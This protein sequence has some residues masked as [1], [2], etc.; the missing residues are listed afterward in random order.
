ML[1]PSRQPGSL[2]GV[3]RYRPILDRQCR[4]IGHRLLVLESGADADVAFVRDQLGLQAADLIDTERLLGNAAAEAGAPPVP[5]SGRYWLSASAAL[6]D[7]L[8]AVPP[9]A[10]SIVWLVP[11]Q[12]AAS[13]A[14]Y[15]MCE[16][17]MQRGHHLAVRGPAAELASIRGIE[18]FTALHVPAGD[19][20]ALATLYGVKRSG[21][22]LL[23]EP[24]DDSPDDDPASGGTVRAP[25]SLFDGVEGFAPIRPA[26]A[27]QAGAAP[28]YG[29]VLK[30]LQMLHS[31]ADAAEIE[32]VLRVDPVLS[33][34][35][36]RYANAAAYRGSHS[37][38]SVRSA[39][40]R[41]GYRQFSRWLALGLVTSQVD[42]GGD[43]AQI[44]RA[45]VRGLTME[46]IA[47][48]EPDA[49]VRE[50]A[51]MIGLFS[52]IDGI[53]GMPLAA[54]AEAAALPEPLCRALIA[55]DGD[56]YPLLA[57]AI[58]T[59]WRP[60]AGQLA[61]GGPAPAVVDTLQPIDHA[62]IHALM[63]AGSLL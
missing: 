41:V 56:G 18:R 47:R 61:S 63:T 11:M 34:R 32:A 24:D 7:A 54:L 8:C 29:F 50:S 13:A 14:G 36:L 28:T 4:L 51:F 25:S 26:R 3:V 37:V 44:G 19:E 10:S 23:R 60:P 12:I 9:Q 35:L 55:H 58:D 15:A 22:L 39:I 21:C 46:T 42:R 53:L 30:A 1:A 17:A 27:E 33:F 43:L 38:D 20:L 62:L 49:A 5:P 6:L 52:L 40:L 2:P 31:D 59:E 16:R 45:V 48:R 57:R